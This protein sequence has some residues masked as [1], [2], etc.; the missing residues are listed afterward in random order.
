MAGWLADEAAD[1]KCVSC[2]GLF[3]SFVPSAVRF[4][5]VY[6]LLS[7]YHSSGSAT[8]VGAGWRVVVGSSVTNV[9]PQLSGLMVMLLCVLRG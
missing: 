1:S 3:Y 9:S 2:E 6:T 7:I 5:F 4:L 8:A